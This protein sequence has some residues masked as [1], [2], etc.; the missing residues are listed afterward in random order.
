MT[1]TVGS[2]SLLKLLLKCHIKTC[3]VEKQKVVL[4]KN[5]ASLIVF[6]G[7]YGYLS[8]IFVKEFI[9]CMW[10]CCFEY[11]NS[12]F[13]HCKSILLYYDTSLPCS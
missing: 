13:F 1:G 11:T 8:I 9:P 6:R 5:A 7:K 2:L 10:V 4:A 12:T 3:S